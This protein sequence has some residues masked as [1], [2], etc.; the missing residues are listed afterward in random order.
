MNSF[1]W[2]TTN[3]VGFHRYTDA[4]PEVKFLKNIHRHIFYV[5]IWIEVFH[6]DRDIEFFLF[7]SFVE[8]LIKNKNL[9][10]KSCEAISDFFYKKISTKFPKRKIKIEI[11]EDNE[12]GSLKEYY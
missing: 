4:P 11:S 1:I 2:I 8:S 5:K 3:F 10:N 9:N 7:K 6:N 12:N